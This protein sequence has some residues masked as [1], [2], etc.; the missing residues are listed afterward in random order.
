MKNKY[1]FF[2]LRCRKNWFIIVFLKHIFHQISFGTYILNICFRYSLYC[3]MYLPLFIFA[4]KGRE[5]FWFNKLSIFMINYPFRFKKRWFLKFNDMHPPTPRNEWFP[6]FGPKS[7]AIF[8]NVWNINFPNFGFW[9]MVEN[10]TTWLKKNCLKRC[11]MFWNGIFSFLFILR[12][13]RFCYQHS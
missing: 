8:V 12:Y 13:V 3:H 10:L 9:D 2:T 4:C 11:A 5:Q 7:C 1:P 6:V